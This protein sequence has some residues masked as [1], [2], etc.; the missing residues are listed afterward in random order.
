VP[1][2]IYPRQWRWP[3]GQK[4]AMSV[5]LAFEAFDPAPKVRLTQFGAGVHVYQ[6]SEPELPLGIAPPVAEFHL[7]AIQEGYF[8][9]S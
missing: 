3:D 6:K 2:T 5:G 8:L 9:T 7:Q 1:A 4:M